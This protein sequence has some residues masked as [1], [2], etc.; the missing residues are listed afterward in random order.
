M[1][2]V[3]VENYIAFDGTK[4]EDKYECK[5][6]EK[7]KVYEVKALFRGIIVGYSTES[8]I[9]G[10]GC[11]DSECVVAFRPKSNLDI[12]IA[13]DYANLMGTGIPA[14][15]SIG[16]T[17]YAY[18]GCDDNFYH[19]G[20]KDEILNR[21]RERLEQMLKNEHRE[22]EAISQDQTTEPS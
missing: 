20:T 5:K 3:T 21:I 19:L 7:S 2:K 13:N 18:V 8:D 1:R 16:V 4:F 17:Y 11:G 10:T 22:D 12:K 9:Y 14:E 6:Y 15:L